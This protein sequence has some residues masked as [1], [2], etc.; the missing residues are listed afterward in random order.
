MTPTPNSANTGAWITFNYIS[1]GAAAA[2]MALG[3]W[4]LPTDLW[5]KGYLAMGAVFLTGSCF[6]LAK[7]LRD[8][9]EARRFT[10]RIE[11]AKTEKLLR[12]I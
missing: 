3:I 1:F 12:E 11:E 10:N 8:E 2:M 5:V 6:T 4:G 9:H 7:T